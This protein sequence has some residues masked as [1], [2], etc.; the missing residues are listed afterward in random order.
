VKQAIEWVWRSASPGSAAARALL[1]PASAAYRVVTGLRNV[2]YDRGLFATHATPIPVVSI[3]NL[4]V[5]GTGKTPVAAWMARQL[6]MR[7][8]RPALVMRGYG[9]DEPKVHALLNPGIE[10]FVLADRV[11]AVRQAASGGHDVAIL[12]DGFQHRRIDRVEDVVLVSA[13]RWREPVR[14]LPTGPWR[15]RL[16]ALS[17]ASFIIVTR[18][19]AGADVSVALL[20]RLT[21]LHGSREGAVANLR[22]S[23]LHDAVHG[24]QRP[25]STLAG[26]S[27]LA[28]GGI[29]DPESFAE[30]LRAAGARVHLR[31][32]PD[33]HSYSLEEV[34]ELTVAAGRFDHICC[35]LKDAVKLAPRWPR[36]GHPLWYVSLRCEIEVGESG[37]TAL[38]DRVLAAR[39]VSPHERRR[40]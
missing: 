7:G 13:D 21:T 29:G 33:H 27:V 17:R 28:V 36:E 22:P 23:A 25:L 32:Y 12:D 40:P 8:A 3:G 34:K 24:A 10:V 5:G 16:N 26:A 20:R 35:T 38:I 6:E 39:P 30:Q 4:S 9:G 14:L 15:E 18:K 31:R 2:L 11:A 19:A 1:A 37:V